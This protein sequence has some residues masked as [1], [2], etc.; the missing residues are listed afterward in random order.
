MCVGESWSPFND[1]EPKKKKKKAL[2]LAEDCSWRFGLQERFVWKKARSGI[3][4]DSTM[5]LMWNI[6]KKKKECMNFWRMGVFSF[7]NPYM[8]GNLGSADNSF[9]LP[10]PWPTSVGHQTPLG[11]VDTSRIRLQACASPFFFLKYD[12]T[13][14]GCILVFGFYYITI[15]YCS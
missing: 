3:W 6:W 4:K 15:H 8:R 7:W 1:V 13:W 11:L 5:C 9:E 2:R 12:G 14:P 10:C